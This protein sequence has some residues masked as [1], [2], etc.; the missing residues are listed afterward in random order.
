MI[1]HIFNILR[2]FVKREKKISIKTWS[3]HHT[4]YWNW[5]RWILL[6]D[7]S[8]KY[9]M[10]YLFC[11]WKTRT[12]R[13]S[14][15]PSRINA[16]MEK[17]YLNIRFSSWKRPCWCALYILLWWYDVE[18]YQIYIQVCANRCIRAGRFD[19]NHN[20]VNPWSWQ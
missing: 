10:D 11:L 2:L 4:S 5:Q 9:E 18:I 12:V 1:P 16:F 6:K 13:W 20:C 17:F 14:V 8:V 19:K 3:V 7:I 15:W